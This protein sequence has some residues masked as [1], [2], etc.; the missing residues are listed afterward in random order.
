M[1]TYIHAYVHTYIHTYTHT[2]IRT[3]IYT[4]LK[5]SEKV[6]KLYWWFA[7]GTMACFTII[8][9]W[10]RKE[11]DEWNTHLRF[12]VLLL[13]LSPLSI[14]HLCVFNVRLRL[15]YGPHA[16][17]VHQIHVKPCTATVLYWVQQVATVLSPSWKKTWR[18]LLARQ[19]MYSARRGG[20]ALRYLRGY[21]R[22]L[23]RLKNTPKALI[24]AQ[25][26][27]YF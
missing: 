8:T 10:P 20:G 4:W 9:S 2:Y 24:S 23:S 6:A 13:I 15:S 21:I 1:R 3:Y 22:S 26:H 11:S 19:G 18:D 7:Q 27:P 25:K 16:P 12:F 17:G 5:K 14:A